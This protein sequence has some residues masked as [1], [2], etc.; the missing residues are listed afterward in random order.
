MKL[1]ITTLNIMALSVAF[2]PVML[3]DPNILSVV[4]LNVAMLNVVAPSEEGAIVIKKLAS[5]N[6]CSAV[7]S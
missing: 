7:I 3:S 5:L 6:L 4:M 1:S 2:K